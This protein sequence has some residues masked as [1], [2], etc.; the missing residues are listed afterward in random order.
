MRIYRIKLNYTK[1]DKAAF[2]FSRAE[3]LKYKI[4]TKIGFLTNGRRNYTIIYL[5]RIKL[6]D[7]SLIMSL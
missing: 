3:F 6:H 2:F 1:Y 7:F 4:L 5:I